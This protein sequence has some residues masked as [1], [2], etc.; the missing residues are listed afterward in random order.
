MKT[1]PAI[2]IKKSIIYILGLFIL[3]LG[4]AFSVK[5][6]L[7]VSP[8]TSVPF[9]LSRI[10][11]L[12]LGAWTAF[13][14]VFC[15]L[16]QA[17]ILR[18][19]YRPIYLFQI[20][21]SFLFGYFTDITLWLLTFLPLTENYVFRIVYLA[22]G[23][24]CIAL[25]VMFYLTTSL[26]SLPT[27]GTVQAIAY[28]G[29]YKLYKVKISYDVASAAIALTLSLAVLGGIEGLGVGTIVASFG[30]GRMLGVFSKLLKP[31]LLR[32]I[33]GDKTD[34]SKGQGGPFSGSM[35]KK[36]V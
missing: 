14:Y 8:V 16:L 7:G 28:K 34:L 5:S 31:K 24:A 26:I 23:I 13:F 6:N 3:A 29:N 20:L 21:V 33:Y 25:G 18:R 27:D 30:V 1:D 9:V 12:S 2:W 32:F 4:I 17:I 19:E 10:F 15:M 22:A 11:G 35:P 36:S